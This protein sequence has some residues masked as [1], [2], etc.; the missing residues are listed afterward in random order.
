MT[1]KSGTI[2]EMSVRQAQSL[3]LSVVHLYLFLRLCLSH[4]SPHY[5]RLLTTIF[6]AINI[7]GHGYDNEEI[8]VVLSKNVRG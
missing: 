3:R 1:S 5:Y 4:C 8:V 6:I 7:Y 2:L